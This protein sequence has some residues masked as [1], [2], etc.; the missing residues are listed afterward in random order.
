LRTTGLFGAADAEVIP[1]API[2]VATKA[3]AAEAIQRL[4]DMSFFMPFLS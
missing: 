1:V 2:A 3:A 4:L